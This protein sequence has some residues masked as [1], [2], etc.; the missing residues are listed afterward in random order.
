MTV[1]Q[2]TTEHYNRPEIKETILYLSK[3]GAYNRWGNGDG[4]GWYKQ[5]SDKKQAYNLGNTEDYNAIVKAHRTLYWSLNL[6]D[7]RIFER[8]YNTVTQEE[9]PLISRESTQGYTLGVDIDKGH[10]CDIHDPDVKKAVEAMGQF[11]ADKLREH[12]PNSVHC[13]FSGGGIYV[14]LHHKAIEA[15][16]TKYR[17]SND[18]EHMLNILLTAYG[19]VIENIRQEFFKLHPE[20]E[21]K[22]KPDSLNNSKRVFKSLFS[23][24]LKQ[25]Y[26]V[27]PL[28]PD[29]VKI[30][31]DKS[32]VP[33]SNEVI[34]SGRK[35]YQTYD[36]DNGFLRFMKPYLEKAQDELSKSVFTGTS[37]GKPSNFDD[38][39]DVSSAPIHVENWPPCVK[40]LLN[41]ESCGEGRTRALAFLAAFMGQ[42]GIPEDQAKSIFDSIAS[43]WGA[44]TSN[45]FTSN[46]QKMHVATCNNL[47]SDDN[48]GYPKGVSIRNL[49][50][51]KPDPR[52]I[53]CV[54]PRYYA[55]K[56]ANIER[57]KSKLK[58]K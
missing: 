14:L 12:A 9:S 25:P 16:F 18:W 17:N 19:Y 56:T 49:G 4:W 50:I 29:N 7:I 58:G 57:L 40:N 32:G 21:G 13:L 20:H 8:D 43:K 31:F 46:Y 27:I 54:S 1:P 42:V 15:Y 10:G 26:A 24:H 35:W 30:D 39:N 44:T 23:I 11:Y 48:T 51:C 5:E 41:L 37:K 53:N 6:F 34:E 2:W 45:V 36:T 38:V 33:L 55:D 47:R 28:D 3:D 22:V 52:C